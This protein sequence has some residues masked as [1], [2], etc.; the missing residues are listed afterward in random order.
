M[1]NYIL[2]LLISYARILIGSLLIFFAPEE[3]KPG[4]IYFKITQAII[5]VLVLFFTLLSFRLHMILIGAVVLFVGLLLYLKK[6]SN[7]Y[8]EYGLFAFIFYLSAKNVSLFLISSS[9]IFVY[10]LPT[11]SLLAKNKRKKETMIRLLKYIYYP[12]IAGILPF[13]ISNF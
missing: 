11:G 3:Q 5:F 9:L 10:G 1:L 8:I 6:M 4:R 2:V 13:L 12:V 7:S